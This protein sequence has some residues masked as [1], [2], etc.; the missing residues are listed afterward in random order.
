MIGLAMKSK[1]LRLKQNWSQFSLLVLVNA[2]VGAMIGLE[3][4]ILPQIAESEFHLA[5]KSAILSFI[6]LFGLSKAFTNFTGHNR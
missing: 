6:V 1:Q 2:F 5:A 4:S 3:P